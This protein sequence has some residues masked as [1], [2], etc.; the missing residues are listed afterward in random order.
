[1][2]SE[3]KS[4]FRGRESEAS[5]SRDTFSEEGKEGKKKLSDSRDTSRRYTSHAYKAQTA[6]KATIQH[7]RNTQR[8]EFGFVYVSISFNGMFCGDFALQLVVTG[9]PDAGSGPGGPQH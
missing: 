9:S 5:G 4:T 8:V 7:K 6:L 3:N 1:L 2:R